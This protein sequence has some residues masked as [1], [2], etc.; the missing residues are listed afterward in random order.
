M[1]KMLTIGD[2][3]RG[4]GSV[5]TV[6]DSIAEIIQARKA[7]KL[8]GLLVVWQEINADGDIINHTVLTYDDATPQV[9]G[10]YS[11]MGGGQ[12][13]LSDVAANNG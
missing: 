12:Q 1:S 2:K 4:K 11:L 13:A 9:V 10:A 8:A 7:G 3:R 6:D 5:V